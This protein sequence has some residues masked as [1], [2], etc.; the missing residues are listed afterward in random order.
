MVRVAGE[1]LGDDI[2]CL[3]CEHVLDGSP[4]YLAARDADGVWQFLCNRTHVANDA[5]VIGL[6]EAVAIEPRLLL[7]APLGFGES[8][9]LH[10]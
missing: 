5:R 8:A 4:I 3:T 1:M 2:A 6:G 9:L 10:P 7:L